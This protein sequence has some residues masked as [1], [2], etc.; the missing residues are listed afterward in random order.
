LSR[1][2]AYEEIE[3]IVVKVPATDLLVFMKT[4]AIFPEEDV[5]P[6]QPVKVVFGVEPEADSSRDEPNT[7]L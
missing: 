2:K 5:A 7:A 6:I 3:L 4:F 1:S